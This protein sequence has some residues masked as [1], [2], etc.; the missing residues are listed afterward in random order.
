[1]E[2]EWETDRQTGESWV[3]TQLFHWRAGEGGGQLDGPA[4]VCVCSQESLVVLRQLVGC[5]MSSMKS[6]RKECWYCFKIITIFCE[7]LL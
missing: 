6:F 4:C 1:M 7:L 3:P 5:I 2:D